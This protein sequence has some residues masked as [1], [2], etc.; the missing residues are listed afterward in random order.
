MKKLAA[1]VLAACVLFGFA[2]CKNSSGQ[3]GLKGAS[4]KKAMEFI[5]PSENENKNALGA[6]RS[7]TTFALHFSAEMLKQSEGENFICSPF[8]VWMPLAALINATDENHKSELLA[9]LGAQGFTEQDVNEAASQMLYRINTAD[10]ES[11]ES[12]TG[13]SLSVVNAIFVDER[14]KLKAD[15]AQ[16]FMDYYRGETFTVDFESP[17]AADAVNKWASESTNGL[18]DNVIASFDPQTAAA[19]ANSVYFHD[20]WKWEFSPEKT[21]ENTFYA[22]TE[23]TTA[24]F[25]LREGDKQR[26]YEDDAVQMMPLEFKTGGTMYIILPKN[27]DA[28]AFLQS[29][30][31]EYLIKMQQNSELRNGT[32]LLPRFEIESGVVELNDTLE[33]MG[34]PLFNSEAAPLTGG[35]IESEDRMWLSAAVQKAAIKVDEKG[36]TAA[37][38]TVFDVLPES[39]PETEP[40]PPFEMNCNTPFVFI[41]K[42]RGQIIFTGVVNRP[43]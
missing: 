41:L 24:H 29:L 3:A 32:L 6:E 43:E 17:S 23:E 13:T 22:P 16:T 37:A 31:E 36:T 21:V 9:A 15:F 38:V 14:Y 7:T 11:Y 25:M 10:N 34:V 19:A 28:N 8:S 33:A 35:L 20:R 30:N 1:L 12:E 5:A 26:Y 2:G 27:G 40:A 42:D 18:I 4:T 39:A